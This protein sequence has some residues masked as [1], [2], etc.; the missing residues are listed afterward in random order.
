MARKIKAVYFNSELDHRLLEFADGLQNFSDWVKRRIEREI[1]K[2][3][4]GVDPEIAA[5]VERLV[6]VKLAGRLVR[7]EENV[8]SKDTLLEDID[9]FF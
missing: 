5:L 8:E 7:S 2:Y 4:T 9:K 3:E 6:E 1:V